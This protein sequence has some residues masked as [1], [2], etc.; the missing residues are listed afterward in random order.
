MPDVP[1]L[2]GTSH[3]LNDGADYAV[4]LV[5]PAGDFFFAARFNTPAGPGG[6][7]DLAARRTFDPQAQLMGLLKMSIAV[8]QRLPVQVPTKA[9]GTP[10]ELAG[11][12]VECEGGAMVLL[13]HVVAVQYLGMVV[14]RDATAL[15]TA[16]PDGRP[17]PHYF[18]SPL[19]KFWAED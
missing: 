7:V 16:G 14:D 18:G 8:A 9:D 2:G 1:I 4:K 3:P 11:P 13:T 6:A 5:T 10:V 19:D 12:F 15:H 17:V